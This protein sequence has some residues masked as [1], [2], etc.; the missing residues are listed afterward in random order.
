MYPYTLSVVI[1]RKKTGE[2]KGS[3]ALLNGERSEEGL[4]TWRKKRP[5]VSL[6]MNR[7]GTLVEWNVFSREIKPRLALPLSCRRLVHDKERETRP[8]RDNGPG[9]I[10]S[11]NLIV[12]RPDVTVAR[13]NFPRPFCHLPSTS[14]RASGCSLGRLELLHMC[15]YLGPMRDD[16]I[17]REFASRF[18][19]FILLDNCVPLLLYRQSFAYALGT[20]LFIG[21]LWVAEGFAWRTL[22]LPWYFL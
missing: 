9:R 20:R 13:T 3:T 17:H 11:I 6:K 12:L 4:V 18:C 10:S 7:S 16:R 19:A 1:P 15:D 14:I 22:R 8:G 2:G 5:T 21:D